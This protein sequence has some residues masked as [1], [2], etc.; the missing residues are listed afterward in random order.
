MKKSKLNKYKYKHMNEIKCMHQDNIFPIIS[1]LLE[2][3]LS[4][5]AI[6]I[7]EQF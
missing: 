4:N 1:M 7:D 2:D 3:K 5:K 6:K